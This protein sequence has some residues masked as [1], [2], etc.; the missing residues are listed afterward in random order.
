MSI[1]RALLGIFVSLAFAGCN[2][3]GASAAQSKALPIA[4]TPP[5]ALPFA[6]TGSAAPTGQS[7]RLV[8][9]HYFPSFPLVIART[10]VNGRFAASAMG[11]YYDTQYLQPEGEAGK[12][13]RGRGYL[14]ERPLLPPG[15]IDSPITG[16]ATDIERARRIGIDGFGIDLLDLDGR[17]WRTTLAMLNAASD[18]PDFH[19]LPEPDMYVLKQVSATTLAAALVTFA[20]HRAAWRLPDGRLLVMPYAAEWKPPAFWRELSIRMQDAGQPIALVPLFVNLDR[21]AANASRLQDLVPL[22]WGA[23]AWGDH[24]PDARWTNLASQQAANAVG[25]ARWLA[26]VTA[27]DMRPKKTL[28]YEAMG[29][30]TLDAGFKAAIYGNAFG[31]HLITWNDYTEG[32]EFAP[33]SGTRHAFYDLA[34][35]YIAWFKTGHQPT[36][37]R[38]AFIVLHR[39]QIFSPDE[40]ARGAAWTRA[41]GISSAAIVEVRAF[42]MAAV[43]LTVTMRGK[44]TAFDL[45]AGAHRISV[46]ATPGTVHVAMFRDGAAI[47]VCDSLFPIEALPSRHDPLYVG[48]SSLR[49]CG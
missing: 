39:R 25:Y 23:T 35:W 3:P 31:V 16:F 30:D 47:A 46:P 10:D 48:F 1:P 29:S 21:R 9:A 18:V 13:A 43:H 32:T 45:K 38:D 17:H 36:I 37:T 14:R 27:Q 2:Q 28:F 5:E 44:T 8:I 42:L 26:P 7:G 41:G 22:S 20:R 6:P 11:D 33:S 19:I 24:T 49:D 4:E 34:A 15:G 12:W 40:T